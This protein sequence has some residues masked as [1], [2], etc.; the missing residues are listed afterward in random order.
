MY[1]VKKNLSNIIICILIFGLLGTIVNLFIVPQSS[2]H[3]EYY[4]IESTLE[5]NTIANLNVELNNSVNNISDSVKV[6][7]VSGG[8]NVIGL[9][10][11]TASGIN[12]ESVR[13][14][15]L[16]VLNNQGITLSDNI[17][18]NI[19]EE[20]NNILKIAIILLGLIIGLV[21]GLIVAVKNKNISTED[22]IQHFL[23]ERTL[24]TF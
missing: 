22:D 4:T 19:Y 21:L 7:E 24:G 1:I 3:E 11:V 14:Q 17:S 16:D 8:G 2:T 20:E 9:N 6:A 5:Q 23:G 18:T 15:T 13:A 12:Y 10:I